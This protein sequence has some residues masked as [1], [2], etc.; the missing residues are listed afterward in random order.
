MSAA[1]H[2]AG[3]PVWRFFYGLDGDPDPDWVHHERTGLRWQ[4]ALDL[5]RGVLDGFD[6]GGCGDCAAAVASVKSVL[7]N[8]SPGTF[9]RETVDGEDLLVVLDEKLVAQRVEA[10]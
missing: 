10:W 8:A 5:A 3:E 7:R 1:P 2:V 6:H 9:V 4:E